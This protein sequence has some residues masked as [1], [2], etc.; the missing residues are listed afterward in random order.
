MTKGAGWSFGERSGTDRP[1][2]RPGE[3]ASARAPLG[4]PLCDHARVM[5]PSPPTQPSVAASWLRTLVARRRVVVL[6]LVPWLALS[7]LYV[8]SLPSRHSAVSVVAIVPNS[9]DVAVGDVV[10]LTASRYAVALTA[11]QRLERVSEETGVPVKDLQRNVTVD[12]TP[13]SGNIRI[14]A[15]A[16]DEDTA[17]AVADAVADEAGSLENGASDI[18]TEKVSSAVLQDGSLLNSPAVLLAGLSLA[19]L[20]L[21]LWMALLVE[22]VRPL[23][24]DEHDVERLLRT[25]SLAVVEGRS[26]TPHGVTRRAAVAVQAHGLRTALHGALAAAPRT[27]AVVGVGSTQGT[28]DTA[29]V[30]ARTLASRE[31]VLLIDGD[32]RSAGLSTI[33]L[34]VPT[35]PLDV[36]VA[37]R[38]VPRMPG[39][40]H[41]LFVLTQAER[42]ELRDE[43][44]E[45]TIADLPGFVGEA[46]ELWDT[47]VISA[48]V[49]SR[50]GDLEQS[51]VPGADAIVVL[52]QGTTQAAAATVG[53]RVRRLHPEV[54]GAVLYVGSSGS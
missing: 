14:T 25:R 13:P 4:V 37:R 12:T 34:D 16:E 43:G 1:H 5:P 47:V 11:T 24:R 49:F 33:S 18:G 38:R 32:V 9:P 26:A 53:R 23:V 51:P 48:P 54:R 20:A 46:G 21:A 50:D 40:D 17:T 6:V 10:P 28:A 15:T 31:R 36:A 27:V 41:G 45:R 29:L 7:L 8:A 35:A 2:S 52:P 44:G 3:P 42:D 39:L 30:V 19:G 22:R